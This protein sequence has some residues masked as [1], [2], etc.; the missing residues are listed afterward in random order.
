MPLSNFRISTALVTL[1][2][3]FLAV[4]ASATNY[5]QTCR[6]GNASCIGGN[7]SVKDNVTNWSFTIRDNKADGNC[8]YAKII[9]DRDRLPDVESDSPRACGNGSTKS[10]AGK[11]AAFYR[12]VGARVFAC[13]DRNLQ[14]DSCD[15]AFYEAER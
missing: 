7:I 3:M 13:I 15:E 9:I 5:P 4:P 14:P 6:L 10:W 8:A 11:S 1:A 2:S 12:T